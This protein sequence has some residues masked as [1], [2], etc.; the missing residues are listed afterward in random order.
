VQSLRA[1]SFEVVAGSPEALGRLMREDAVINAKIVAEAN[2][3]PE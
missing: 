3:K 1:Q 2:I